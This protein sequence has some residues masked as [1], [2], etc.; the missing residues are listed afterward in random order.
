[1]KDLPL[2][3]RLKLGSSITY[4]GEESRFLKGCHVNRREFY[5]DDTLQVVFVLGPRVQSRY[6]GVSPNFCSVG[7]DIGYMVRHR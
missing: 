6:N 3:L 7:T 2:H 4:A 5:V 1:V